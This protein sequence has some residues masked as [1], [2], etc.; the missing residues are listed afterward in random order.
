MAWVL[1]APCARAVRRSLDHGSWHGTA[2]PA[3]STLIWRPSDAS[4]LGSGG[5]LVPSI[6]S[7]LLCSLRSPCI[8]VAL[9]AAFFCEAGLLGVPAVPPDGSEAITGHSLRAPRAQGL[10]R[11]GLD[12]W[13]AQLFGRWGSA[14]VAYAASV[15]SRWRV[16]RYGLLLRSAAAASLRPWALCLSACVSR[17]LRRLGFSGGGLSGPA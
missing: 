12:T 14:T 11:L 2:R 9:A 15:P 13:T 3:R 17:P 1:T 5:K 7:P 6:L 8:K 4:S 16:R 10:Y